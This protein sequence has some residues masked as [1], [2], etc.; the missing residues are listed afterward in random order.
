MPK[1]SPCQRTSIVKMYI[2]IWLLN[3]LQAR[4]EST[5]FISL[6]YPFDLLNKFYKVS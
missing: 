3:I 6:T 4:V 2:S 1:N 5:N